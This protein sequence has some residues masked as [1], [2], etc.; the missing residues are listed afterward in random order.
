MEISTIFKNKE[1][2]QENHVPSRILFREEQFKQIDLVLKDLE[3]GARPRNILG[4]GDMAT[5]KTL[6]FKHAYARLPATSYV[7]VNCNQDKTQR[8]ILTQ[9]LT[10]MGIQ[11]KSGHPTTYYWSMLKKHQKQ[12]HPLIVTL[13]EVDNFVEHRDSGYNE[14]F[15]N[16]SREIDNIVITLLTNRLDF[17]S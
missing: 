4:V 6:V 16:I 13:D 7:Y 8:N 11:V 15:Y 14:F 17:E 12:K 10:G 9:I 3:R 1:V 5:G 2:F